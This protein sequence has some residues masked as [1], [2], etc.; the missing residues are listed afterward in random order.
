MYLQS[1]SNRIKKLILLS[2]WKATDEKSRIRIR[3]S[4][5]GS[6]DPD[7]SQNVTDL[8]HW[9]LL[10]TDVTCAGNTE[11]CRGRNPAGEYPPRPAQGVKTTRR[12]KPVLTRYSPVTRAT[13]FSCF[14]PSTASV[15]ISFSS[16][17]FSVFYWFSCHL[18]IFILSQQ[19]P[20]LK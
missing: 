8:K 2:S 18:P 3:K 13:E 12:E 20:Q 10:T 5:H 19:R 4:V 7:P 14:F 1:V 9:F 15:F 16:S 17:P 11:V 6:K